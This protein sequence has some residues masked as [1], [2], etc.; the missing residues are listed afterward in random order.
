MIVFDNGRSG[1]NGEHAA[2]DGTPTS[3]MNDWM[4]KSLAAGK[5]DLGSSTPTTDAQLSEPKPITLKLDDS[6]KQAIQTAIKNH[7]AELAKHKISV[8]QYNGYGKD[9]CVPFAET[10]GIGIRADQSYFGAPQDQEVQD[11]SRQLG[12][13]RHA[14]R[15]LQD[16]GLHGA[17]RDV[18]VVPDAKIPPRED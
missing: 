12:A 2:M 9:L 3:R 14:V 13:A 4:L 18:R 7:G 1:F 11:V 16:D 10:L 5:I 17:R 6:S 15:V 8:L